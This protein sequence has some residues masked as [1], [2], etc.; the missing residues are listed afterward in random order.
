M[1]KKNNKGITLIALVIT[2][3]VLLILA[4]ISISALTQTG[5]FEKAKEAKQ[6]NENTQKE[7][8][9]TLAN[10]EN[11][12]NQIVESSSR[13][14][15]T[16]IKVIDTNISGEEAILEKTYTVEES[17]KIVINLFSCK[18]SGGSSAIEFYCKK[19]NENISP[20]K[21]AKDGSQRIQNIYVIDVN[22]DDKIECKTRSSGTWGDNGYTIL[23][24]K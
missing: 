1:K 14:K 18:G 17:G 13:E 11:E 16:Q 9:L 8:N 7:E 22:K 4:G 21:Q 24:I 5:I 15:K 2:I 23:F 3:I 6:K 19:N 12:I 20:I 10:Y